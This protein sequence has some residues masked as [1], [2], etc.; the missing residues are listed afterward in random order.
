MTSL[1][2]WIRNVVKTWEMDHYY[3]FICNCCWTNSCVFHLFPLLFKIGHFDLNILSQWHSYDRDTYCSHSHT[4]TQLKVKSYHDR[5]YD[6]AHL[7]S[8]FWLHCADVQPSS[9]TKCDNELR[10]NGSNLDRVVCVNFSLFYGLC[11]LILG[12]LR[13]SDRYWKVC[14][15]IH[16]RDRC[17][18]FCY[19]TVC[20][21][22]AFVTP[23]HSC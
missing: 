6:A 5:A 1:A 15:A 16:L 7:S 3:A 21:C 20:C 13:F 17:Q 12:P 19:W 8:R 10:H 23:A 4:H 18:I 11:T 14:C 9:Q 2:V 22:W